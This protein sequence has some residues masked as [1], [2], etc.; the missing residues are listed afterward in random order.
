MK[1][2]YLIDYSNYAYKFKSVFNF[3]KKVN[4]VEYNMSV[5]YGFMRCLKTNPFDHIHICLDG[6]PEM[7]LQIL[8]SYKGQRIKEPE[9]GLYFPKKELIKFLTKYGEVLG[10]DIKV[11]ASAGQ[12]ADQVIASQVFQI[13]GNINKMQMK[14]AN[15]SRK[16]L[17]EDPFLK[18][19]IT[20]GFS[21]K[22][23]DLADFDTVV[24]GT[25]DSDMYQLLSLDN[26][27]IDTTTSGKSFNMGEHT[28]KAVSG[29]MPS[30][31][32]V[33]KAFVG[34]VSDNVPAIKL[35]LK[36]DKLINI[37]NK[38]LPTKEKFNIFIDRIRR[39]ES[40][41]SEEL[42]ILAKM[43]KDTNQL[44]QLTANK[45]IVELTFVSTPF[46]LSYKDYF[47]EDTITKYSLK[48]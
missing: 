9:E 16:T 41:D 18:K 46:S 7:S 30:A 48:V 42:N 11:V 35:S 45:S 1:A 47:I 44:K 38:H 10:K 6:Y 22:E 34:D 8:P 2:L 32:P 5:L 25:T 12:E 33:Y 17:S 24:V 13:V 26:V 28:P 40:Q 27:M 39:G 36:N 29:V 19:F 31:I 3:K 23:L 20:N 43:I 4:G 37:I 21:Q 15:L 14:M